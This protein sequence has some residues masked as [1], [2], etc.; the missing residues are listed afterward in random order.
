MAEEAFHNGFY[1]YLPKHQLNR[2]VVL[3]SVWGALERSRM[4]REVDQATRRVSGLAVRDTVT[5]LWNWRWPAERLDQET[6]CSQCYDVPLARCLFDLGYF[7]KAT[8]PVAT[9]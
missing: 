9:P 3:R 2:S 1:D 4:R 8:T 7:K 6:Q 5:G